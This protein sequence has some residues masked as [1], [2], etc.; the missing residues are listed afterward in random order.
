MPLLV[1]AA[2]T[3]V[4]SPIAIFFALRDALREE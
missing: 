4:L 3:L 1:T 2:A